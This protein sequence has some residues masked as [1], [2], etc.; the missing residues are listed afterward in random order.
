M[1]LSEAI[2]F[3][4]DVRPTWGEDSKSYQTNKI[5]SNH[6]LSVLGDIP[7]EDITPLHYVEIQKHFKRLGKTPGTINR[8][9][10]ALS[11][12]LSELKTHQ[13]IDNPA[14]CPHQLRNPRDG[15][16]ST[17]TRKSRR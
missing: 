9:T 3:V 1:N 17:R 8:I 2:A 10:S 16:A 12:V 15:L 7:V 14:R 13:I 4:R 6:V 5:N 11:T